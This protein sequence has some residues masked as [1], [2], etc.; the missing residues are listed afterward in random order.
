MPPR[1]SQSKKNSKATTKPAVKKTVNKS[2]SG[3]VNA[4]AK[5]INVK[6][7]VVGRD[8]I[9]VNVKQDATKKPAKPLKKL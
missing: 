7:D 6:G 5:K 8:K 4:K 9:V 1:S 2:R 3:G